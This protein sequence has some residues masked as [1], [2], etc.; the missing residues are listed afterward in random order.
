MI[1]VTL[2]K[3]AKMPRREHADDAGLDLFAVGDWMVPAGGYAK[4]ET[5]VHIEIPRGYVGLVTSKSGLMGKGLTCRG[6]IDSNYRGSI[7]AVVYNH[8]DVDYEFAD[9]D[10]VTQLVI[11]PYNMDVLVE[12]E[13]LEETDRGNGG[14]G[15]TGKR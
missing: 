14:F 15:S 4:I 12:V 9:G 10:K 6:T 1:R 13:T 8:G 3:G 5:G 7:K 2:D 11:L